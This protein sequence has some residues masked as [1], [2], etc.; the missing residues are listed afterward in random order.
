VPITATVTPSGGAATSQTITTIQQ[1]G[2]QVALNLLPDQGNLADISIVA[3]TGTTPVLPDAQTTDAPVSSLSAIDVSGAVAS[4]DPQGGQFIKS[5]ALSMNIN[6]SG[7]VEATFITSRNEHITMIGELHPSDG[8]ITFDKDVGRNAEVISSSLTYSVT[9][10][11]GEPMDAWLG[12][13]VSMN[14]AVEGKLPALQDGDLFING[15]NI[16][17]SYASDD[18]LSPPDNAAGSAIAKAAAINRMAVASGVTGGEEQTL[19]LTGTPNPNEIVTIGG[20][21]IQLSGIANTA[22]QA[23]A[24]IY[25]KLKVSSKF[26]DVTGRS[27]SYQSGSS[28]ISIKYAK[29]E[30]DVSDIEFNA[31]ASGLRG[32]VDTTVEHF[33]A[34][35]GTGVFA[36]V[37]ENVMTGNAMTGTSVV[38]GNVFING[39]ASADISTVLNNTRATRSDV[40]RAINMITDKTGVKAIDTG[41]DAKGV[42]LV[43]A[44]GRNIEVRF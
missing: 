22:A 15:V 4:W 14:V 12:R 13:T 23:A 35:A 29:D 17:S 16:G 7:E 31:Q 6:A 37:N 11:D 20:V 2:F 19:T 38:R 9:D 28:V 26:A 32:I 33:T 1:Y 42:I 21:D 34:I 24:E 41:S 30:R 39:Y 10:I 40:V 43:A 3:S 44:D 36:K 5:G 25:A 18:N 8:R 27:V